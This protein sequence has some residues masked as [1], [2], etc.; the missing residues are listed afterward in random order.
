MKRFQQLQ[1][2]QN[3]ALQ[4]L[5][6]VWDKM[7]GADSQEVLKKAPEEAIKANRTGK[8]SPKR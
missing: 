2:D 3:T 7:K 1:E 6:S 4:S 5:K 8:A